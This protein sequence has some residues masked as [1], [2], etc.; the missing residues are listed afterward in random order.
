MKVVTKARPS[1]GFGYLGKSMNVFWQLYIYHLKIAFMN[2]L[3][4]VAL[5]GLLVHSRLTFAQIASTNLDQDPIF[6]KVVSHHIHYPVKP[7]ARA[8][9]GRFYA[10]FRIDQL[11]HIQDISVIYPKMSTRMKKLYGF[12]HEILAGLRHMPP[13]KPSLIGSYILPIA[14]CFTHYGE[15]PN[16]I[17]PTNG[18][19]PAYEVGDRVLL[20]EV[21]I[22]ASSP[23]SS[24]GVT[25]FPA[26]R[27]IDQ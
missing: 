15:G 7:A 18:L 4:K 21:K 2:K 25:G 12:D 8:I 1:L 6:N 9:Y 13:L 20:T 17:V 26:S 22:F 23:S 11:G 24:R 3:T 14:F 5:L 27:Q 16:P 10:G 19:P